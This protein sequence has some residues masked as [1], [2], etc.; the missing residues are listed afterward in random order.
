[1][2]IFRK[3]MKNNEPYGMVFD[4]KQ[5]KKHPFKK[6]IDMVFKEYNLRMGDVILDNKESQ[7]YEVRRRGFKYQ[8]EKLCFLL[9]PKPAHEIL[10]EYI[11][12]W[13]GRAEVS[14]DTQNIEIKYW[15][16]R[17]T[18]ALEGV[19][20]SLEKTAGFQVRLVMDSKTAARDYPGFCT[21]LF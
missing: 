1:M 13:V 9:T 6:V 18:P 17:N 20:N 3:G 21:T 12:D 8:F 19:K 7:I 2:F 14:S 5:I 15:G 11:G 4:Q 16:E 10:N